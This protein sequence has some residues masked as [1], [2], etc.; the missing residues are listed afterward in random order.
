MNW[1]LLL[2]SPEKLINVELEREQFLNILDAV[3]GKSFLKLQQ[4]TLSEGLHRE[5]TRRL[6]QKGV[7]GGGPKTG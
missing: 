6:R 4:P 1:R 3:Y 5:A 2:T 7:Q